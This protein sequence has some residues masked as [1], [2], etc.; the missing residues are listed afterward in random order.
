MLLQP[1][2]CAKNWLRQELVKCASNTKFSGMKL[3]NVYP[4]KKD[5]KV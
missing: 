4:K 5:Q 3:I 2:G 1:D